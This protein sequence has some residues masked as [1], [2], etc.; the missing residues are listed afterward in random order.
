M[1][2]ILECKTKVS[3]VLNILANASR[4]TLDNEQVAKLNDVAFKAIKKSGQKKLDERAL[5]NEQMF[6]DN[7]EIVKKLAKKVDTNKLMD[8]YGEIVNDIGCCPITTQNIVEA[9]ASEDCFCLCL[10]IARSEACIQDP[11]KLRIKRIIPTFMTCDAFMDSSV[12]SLRK[13]YGAHGGFD[14]NEQG[15][16]AMGVAHESVTGILPLYLFKEHW[17]IARRKLMPLF[18]FMCCLEPMGY[19]TS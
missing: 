16:L 15:K 6:K 19:T 10:D 5:K 18:G 14:Y 17:E 2:S 4:E 11:S 3:A 13:N 9:M 12:F 8:V 7:N 1:E